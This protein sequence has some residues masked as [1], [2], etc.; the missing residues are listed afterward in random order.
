[1]DTKE[2]KN[3]ITLHLIRDICTCMPCCNLWNTKNQLYRAAILVTEK[4]CNAVK[5]NLVRGGPAIVGYMD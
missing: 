2:F 1:M 5:R 3:S 4:A